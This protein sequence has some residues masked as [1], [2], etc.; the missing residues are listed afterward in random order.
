MIDTS[1]LDWPTFIHAYANGRWDPHRTP[2]RPKPSTQDLEPQKLP[3][4]CSPNSDPRAPLPES[5]DGP[6]TNV[7]PPSPAAELLPQLS[8]PHE[9]VESQRLSSQLPAT[10]HV[11]PQESPAVQKPTFLGLP[12]SAI[13]LKFHGLR[14]TMPLNLPPH[15]IRNS[16]SNVLTQPIDTIPP[17]TPAANAELQTTV[18]TMRWAAARVDISPLALPSPEHELADPMRG[19]TAAIPGNHP[20]D[21]YQDFP[22][23]P[24]GTRRSRLAEFWEGTTDIEDDNTQKRSSCATAPLREREV[25]EP[26]PQLLQTV[27]PAM[28]IESPTSRRRSHL[29]LLISAPPATAPSRDAHHASSIVQEDYFGDASLE[30]TTVMTSAPTT[31][32]EVTPETAATSN[33]TSAQLSPITLRQEGT[34]L[35]EHG[36]VSVPAAPRRIFLMRQISSPLPAALPLKETRTFGGRIVSDSPPVVKVRRVSREEQLFDELQYLAPPD[37]PDELERRRALYK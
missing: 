34:A 21:S 7:S 19:V 11:L 25:A 30:T 13:P 1:D 33:I 2:H 10:N 17:T 14:T 31:T 16:F 35:P 4:M 18:A 28:D 12:N 29:S 9:N 5:A 3:A 37:P 20:P 26:S 32:A 36:T 6:T 22:I 15:R 8:S 23:T 27:A 24:G